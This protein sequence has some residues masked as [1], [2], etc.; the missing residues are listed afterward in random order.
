VTVR[1]S[2][3]SLFLSVLIGGCSVAP[4]PRLDGVGGVWYETQSDGTKVPI[5]SSIQFF[6]LT[7]DPDKKWVV[8]AVRTVRDIL[9]EKPPSKMDLAIF[10]TQDI[11]NTKPSPISQWTAEA[12][13][14]EPWGS[15][16]MTTYLGCCAGTTTYDIYNPADGALILRHDNDEE[17]FLLEVPNLRGANGNRFISTLTNATSLPSA[18]TDFGG[19]VIM[20]ITYSSSQKLLQRVGLEA[21]NYLPSHPFRVKVSASSTKRSSR[22]QF[23]QYRASLWDVE[24]K[25]M[26]TELFTDLRI[27]FDLELEKKIRVSIPLEGDRMNTSKTQLPAGFRWVNL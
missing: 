21:P 22:S 13:R 9:A 24:N 27:T 8:R 3:S 7:Q 23:Q 15:H 10:P 16:V 12:D 25:S 19:S 17:P 6:P 4:K 1:R 26:P 14:A 11:A 2:V 18:R 5:Y 20:V